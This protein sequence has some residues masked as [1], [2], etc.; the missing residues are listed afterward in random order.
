MRTFDEMSGIIS[1]NKGSFG[2]ELTVENLYVLATSAF[3][4]CPK[5]TREEL[6]HLRQIDKAEQVTEEEFEWLKSLYE[7]RI[8]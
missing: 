7:N 6:K 5:L 8:D 2:K 1:K 4:D 3:G